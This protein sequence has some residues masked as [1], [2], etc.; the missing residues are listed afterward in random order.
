MDRRDA[1]AIAAEKANRRW[2]R[3]QD[4]KVFSLLGLALAVIVGAL[5]W[6]QWTD[7]VHLIDPE[8]REL[9]QA[10]KQIDV[11]C[12]PLKTLGYLDC[13]DS[14]LGSLGKAKVVVN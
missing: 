2:Q 12:R 11:E 8:V 10:W 4:F 6:S 13:R 9:D 5:L 14:I 1:S 3:W 7:L